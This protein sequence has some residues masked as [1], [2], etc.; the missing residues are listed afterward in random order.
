MQILLI[1]YTQMI[2]IKIFSFA[3]FRISYKRIL[4]IYNNLELICMYNLS[5]N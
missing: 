2:I 5:K 1:S 4:F 3:I